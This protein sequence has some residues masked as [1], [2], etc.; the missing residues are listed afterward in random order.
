VLGVGIYQDSLRQTAQSVAT[1]EVKTAT[2][3]AVEPQAK[4]K[5]NLA[6][7]IDL[8]KKDMTV[9]KPARLE[10]FASPPL[11]KRTNFQC[12]R[13]PCEPAKG[14]RRRPQ[15]NQSAYGCAQYIHR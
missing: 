8:P 13:R 1:E 7:A 11:K 15:T 5:A 9:D 6:P 12:G 10:R 3:Q 14:T 4:A 2:L